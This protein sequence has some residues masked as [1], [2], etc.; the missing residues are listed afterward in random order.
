MH[1]LHIVDMV[2]ASAAVHSQT[3]TSSGDV[4]RDRRFVTYLYYLCLGS[5]KSVYL[6][7]KILPAVNELVYKINLA[8]S[9]SQTLKCNSMGEHQEQQLL[10]IYMSMN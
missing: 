10:S 5:P 1:T 8:Q 6:D 7:L 2:S 9:V 3:E 4:L